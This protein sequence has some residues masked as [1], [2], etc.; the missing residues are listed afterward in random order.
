MI[1]F[2]FQ[3]TQPGF[4]QQQLCEMSLE[5]KILQRFWVK[6]K[7]YPTSCKVV[8]MMPPTHGESR[9]RELKCKIILSAILSI[10]SFYDTMYILE[11]TTFVTTRYKNNT[12]RVKQYFP[13][14]IH[15]WKMYKV[16][17]LFLKAKLLKKANFQNS[18]I[19]L[20][21]N[22]KPL[23][24]QFCKLFFVFFLKWSIIFWHFA[25]IKAFLEF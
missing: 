3:V 1:F 6:G 13:L 23:H 9:W 7:Q 19:A 24:L 8:L 11:L 4:W 22:G 18:V 20:L 14:N 16:I 17:P 2:Y 25:Y 10:T 21:K 5:R 12:L 15:Q